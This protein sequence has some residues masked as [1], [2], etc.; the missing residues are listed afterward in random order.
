M[1]KPH[2]E[3][4]CVIDICQNEH[5]DHR[6]KALEEVKMACIQVGASLS[7][8]QVCIPSYA[9]GSKMHNNVLLL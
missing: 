1:I 6:K 4:V 3:V 8:I 7:H 9:Q 5:L 2:M